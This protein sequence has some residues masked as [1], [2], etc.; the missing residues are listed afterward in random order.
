MSSLFKVSVS[1]NHLIV[2][3]DHPVGKD[4]ISETV[5]DRTYVTSRKLYTSF[6]LV[7]VLMTLYDVTVEQPKHTF[8]SLFLQYVV[9]CN[10]CSLNVDENSPVLL[11]AKRRPMSVDSSYV[12]IV[13]QCAE[14]TAHGA[15][16]YVTAAVYG[17]IRPKLLL[18]IKSILCSCR[19]LEV[20]GI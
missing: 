2:N 17:T 18:F 9:L 1:E 6:Q 16:G 3:I 10:A 13:H 19:I 4:N 7:A 8:N 20:F 5:G 14:V 11:A 15:A 12:T